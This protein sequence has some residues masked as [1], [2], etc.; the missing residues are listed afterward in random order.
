M[1]VSK[2]KTGFLKT[3]R[4]FQGLKK[5]KNRLNKKKTFFVYASKREEIQ[6]FRGNAVQNRVLKFKILPFV[7]QIDRFRENRKRKTNIDSPKKASNIL[8]KGDLFWQKD[9]FGFF[10]VFLNPYRVLCCMVQDFWRNLA[11]IVLVAIVIFGAI[12]MPFGVIN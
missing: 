7:D 8:K 2:N 12:F 10:V 4:V 11:K 6:R 5:K 9:D 3:K 1:G